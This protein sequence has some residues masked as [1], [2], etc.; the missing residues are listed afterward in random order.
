MLR[1]KLRFF[2]KRCINES[3][4]AIVKPWLRGNILDVGC[5]TFLD[6]V[7][8]KGWIEERTRYTGID[9][10][11]Q[12]IR[13]LKARYPQQEFYHL[14]IQGEKLPRF[15]SSFNTVLLIAVIEHFLEPEAALANIKALLKD[16]GILVIT[17]PT[18]LGDKIQ[19]IFSLGHVDKPPLYCPHVRIYNKE[20]LT[21]L[22]SSAGFSV[23]IYRKFQFGGNQLFIC[24]KQGAALQ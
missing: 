11:E 16:D 8:T 15:A 6:R 7:V 9:V 21:N 20:S 24:R 23:I 13:E 12:L 14:D 19:G 17:T 2:F 1:E 22:L 3:R 5:G 4:D 18:L 10:N